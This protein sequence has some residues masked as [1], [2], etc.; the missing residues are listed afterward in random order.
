MGRAL[1]VAVALVSHVATAA[2][3]DARS[4]ADARPPG[5]SRPIPL[6][7]TLKLPVTSCTV[8]DLTS[9]IAKLVDV[10]AGVEYLPEPCNYRD[11]APVAD[12][13]PLVGQTFH[14]V[15][16]LLVKTDPR[17]YWTMSDGVVVMRPLVAWSARDH[18][19]HAPIDGF[20]LKDANIGGAMD[21]IV[22]DPFGNRG[23]G[24]QIMAADPS[25]IT[26][27]SGPLSVAE[28]LDLVVRTHGRARWEVKY[29]QPE[30]RA[31]VANISFYTY[32]GR[33]LG[34]RARFDKD[35]SGKIIDPCHPR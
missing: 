8:P 33:G 29:C 1:V 14:D 4:A 16:D 22:V 10:P 13:I 15:L 21:A 9:H 30:M 26:V 20:D 17:F 31:Q 7:V 23:L 24:A 34:R 3:Q 6:N 18:F 5:L 32:D 27:S 28:A 2:A 11:G 25:S 19:L 35:S 12:E